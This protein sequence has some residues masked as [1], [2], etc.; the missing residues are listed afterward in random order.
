DIQTVI[1][2]PPYGMSF[3]SNFRKEQH[4]KIAN[5]TNTECLDWICRIA[6]S[7]SKYIFCRWDNIKDVPVPKSVITWVKNNWSMGDLL[8]EH[9]RQTETILF[10]PGPRHHF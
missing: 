4:N 3:Q 8:H 7:H 6:A 2:D 9:A 1:T 10:Y 5:D